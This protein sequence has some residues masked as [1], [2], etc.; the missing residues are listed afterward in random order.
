M[1][2]RLRASMA[3]QTP[4]SQM[5]LPIPTPRATTLRTTYHTMEHPMAAAFTADGMGE[6]TEVVSTEA[7]DITDVG[8]TRYYQL[9]QTHSLNHALG[10][11]L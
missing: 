11:H 8:E 7:V 2:R 10:S 6:A 4:R 9:E 5:V 1:V 3:V